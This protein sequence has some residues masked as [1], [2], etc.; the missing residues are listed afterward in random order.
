MTLLTAEDVLRKQ[1]APAKKGSGYDETDTDN[2]LD[3][4]VATLQALDSQIR[5]LTAKVETLPAPIPAPAPAPSAPES[6]TALLQLATKMHDDHIAAAETQA[7]ELVAGARAEA[8]TR[9]RDAR[10]TSQ[11][12]LG[13]LEDTRVALQASVDELTRFRAGAV[14]AL[15]AQL[16]GFIAQ[17]PAAAE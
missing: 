16:E 14:A 11:R 12:E 15:R 6:A 5:E 17:V 13:G 8:Q 3:E 1:L 4:V 9:L 7:Q 10:E 2:F